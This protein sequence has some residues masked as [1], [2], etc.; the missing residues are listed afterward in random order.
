M[1]NSSYVVYDYHEA[2]RSG[3][4]GWLAVVDGLGCGYYATRGDA[5]AR[6]RQG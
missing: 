3:G 5:L 2:S 1:S 4:R 6:V